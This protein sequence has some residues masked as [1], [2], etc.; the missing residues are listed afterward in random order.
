[1]Q[2]NKSLFILSGLLIL[3]L[4]VFFISFI[5]REIPLLMKELGI[6]E[7]EKVIEINDNEIHLC[8]E[9]KCKENESFYGD[10]VLC[11]YFDDELGSEY[12]KCVDI[13]CNPVAL[14]GENCERKK[15]DTFSLKEEV[16]NECLN[17]FK[18]NQ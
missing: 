15:L 5:S 10:S 3:L 7:T 8:L 11:Y 12:C 18:I 1:M 6:K 14:N 16:F 9:N 4:V 17:K 2:T 13:I